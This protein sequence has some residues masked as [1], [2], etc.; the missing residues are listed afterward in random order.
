MKSATKLLSDMLTEQIPETNASKRNL[1]YSSAE[2]SVRARSK[3]PFNDRYK[4][5]ALSMR[6]DKQQL[7]IKKDGRPHDITNDLAG[8][9]FVF[10]VCLLAISYCTCLLLLKI[11]LEQ[12]MCCSKLH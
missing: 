7:A 2:R 1:R 6:S 4:R 10:F 5:K 3:Q 9:G 8:K 11:H 12:P